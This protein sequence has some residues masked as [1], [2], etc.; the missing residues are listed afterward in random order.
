M[1]MQ[2]QTHFDWKAGS[3]TE[4]SSDLTSFGTVTMEINQVGHIRDNSTLL[5]FP[6][7]GLRDKICGFDNQWEKNHNKRK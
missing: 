2:Q 3:R 7:P 4:S 6:E 1:D 5:L